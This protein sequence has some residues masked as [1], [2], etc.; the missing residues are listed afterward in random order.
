MSVAFDFS[1]FASQS[2]GVWQ[3]L[4]QAAMDAASSLERWNF[5][6]FDSV[7]SGIR[8]ELGVANGI[9]AKLAPTGEY[10][11]RVQSGD[12]TPAK[13]QERADAAAAT[14]ADAMAEMHLSAPSFERITNEVIAPT[15]AEVKADVTKVASVGVDLVPWVAAAIIA[16]VLG[17]IVFTFRRA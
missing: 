8:S 6:L 7:V 5:V 17:Y 4:Q 13:W 16:G 14:I 2:R 15:V 11:L 9:I 12:W 10:T 1:T 3:S